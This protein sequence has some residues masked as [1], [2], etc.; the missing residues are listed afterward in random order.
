M[1]DRSP[2]PYAGYNQSVEPARGLAGQG[3]G[4]AGAAQAEH[5]PLHHRGFSSH[6]YIL[7]YNQNSQYFVFVFR[8]SLQLLGSYFLTFGFTHS[9]SEFY[10]Y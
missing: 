3:C 1:I 4:R 2:V 8:E 5:S 10:I 7:F 6:K 9:F